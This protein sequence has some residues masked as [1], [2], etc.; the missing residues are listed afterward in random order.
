M[1][2]IELDVR[3]VP[4][5]QKH[6]KIFGQF[7]ALEPGQSFVLV[8]DHDPRHLRDEFEVE[9][10]GGFEWEYLSREM[11]D[12][13]IR[14]TRLASTPL[15]RSLGNVDDLV[16]GTRDAAGTVWALQMKSR[17]LDSAITRV[18]PDTVVEAHAGPDLDELVLILD[19]AG[20]LTH[21]AESVELRKGEIVWLPRRS[22][23]EISA[24]P[25]GL[26]YLT[27]NQRRESLGLVAG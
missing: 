25:Q 12:W 7:E 13:R 18:L 20:R 26:T 5:P 23:R 16:T 11:R 6:P 14:I 15:P 17:D 24:G 27:V 21:E 19:G 4:K 3:Q 9:H 1:T 8:N 10:P 22:R 2:D